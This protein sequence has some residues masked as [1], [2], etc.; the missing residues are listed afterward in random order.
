MVLVSVMGKLLLVFFQVVCTY[1]SGNKCPFKLLEN[2]RQQ[3]QTTFSCTRNRD[4]YN[5]G[6]SSL[7]QQCG[8]SF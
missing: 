3:V 8:F 7:K 4:S 1:V 6:S 5:M 2:I